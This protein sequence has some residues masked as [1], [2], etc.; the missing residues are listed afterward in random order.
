MVEE[1]ITDGKRIAQL[2]ASELSARET[3][4]L[5]RVEVIDAD[6]DAT[7]SEDGTPAYGIAV[8]EVDVGTASLFPDY[9][10]VTVSVGTDAVIETAGNAGVPARRED[11]MAVLQVESG[12]AVKPAVDVIA[13]AVEHGA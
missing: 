5:A 10:R 1:R 12:A 8:D 13:A 6:R 2:L 11:D 4:P 9:V 7:P 3:G